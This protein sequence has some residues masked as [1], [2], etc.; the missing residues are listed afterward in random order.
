MKK[1]LALVLA[2]FLMIGMMT[3]VSPILER[4]N[5]T[6]PKERRRIPI[7]NLEMKQRR[8]AEGKR[9]P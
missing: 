7:R 8:P 3:G 9:T 1:T 2:L 5:R 4:R 6:H